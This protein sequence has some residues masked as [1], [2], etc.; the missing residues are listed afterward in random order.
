MQKMAAYLKRAICIHGYLE[1]CTKVAAKH[2]L[3]TLILAIF[4]TFKAET[5]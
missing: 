5:F 2:L 4:R 1:T 3:R